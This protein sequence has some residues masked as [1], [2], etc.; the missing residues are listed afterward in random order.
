[1]SDKREITGGAGMIPPDAPRE[2]PQPLR[3]ELLQ[4]Q[5]ERA[6]M[7][8]QPLPPFNPQ[9]GRR[10]IPSVAPPAAPASPPSTAMDALIADV[11]ADTPVILPT[12][13]PT[14][15]EGLIDQYED[16]LPPLTDEDRKRMPA[17]SLTDTP[18]KGLLPNLVPPKGDKFDGI[19]RG[20]FADASDAQYYPI[21]GEELIEVVCTVTDTLIAQI[22]ND[23]RFSMALTYPR[24][25]VR[26]RLE[27]E[28][29]AEDNNAGFEIQKVYVPKEGMGG[30][31]PLEIARA[32]GANEV[33]F[34]VTSTM[35]EF[36]PDGQSDLP[37]DAIRDAIGMPKPR[38]QMVNLGGRQSFVDVIPGQD[39]RAVTR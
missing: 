20:G 25:R 21:T 7:N 3:P 14:P 36:T 2:V 31:T 19:P 22:K 30:S 39:A 17:A 15:E 23:L 18:A 10:S 11:F 28:G 1:M 26:V 27:V 5:A 33:V 9:Q 13:P 35:Q 12:A 4:R 34:V 38:K 24:L 8:E 32:H 29:A 6:R 16:I 37:P